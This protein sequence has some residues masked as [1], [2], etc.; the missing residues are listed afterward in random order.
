MKIK[1][2]QCPNMPWR[3]RP[4]HEHRPVWR[5]D[6]NPVIA[7]N[8]APG[9]ARI[10]NSAVVPWKDHFIG[11]FR[12][13]DFTGVPH[14]RLGRS[15]DGLEWTFE[16]APIRF[17]NAEDEDGMSRYAY[18]PRLV[19]VDGVHY[20]IWC[21]DF[22]GPSIGLAKT[23][24]F[25]TFVRL[26]NAF[27]PFNR[28]GVLFPERIGGVYKMLSR[29]SDNGHTAFGDI[30]I[31]ESPDL[32]HWGRHRRVMGKND[33]WWQNLKIGGGPA[34]IKTDEG[35]LTF[36]HGVTRTCNGYV[37]SMGVALLDLETPSRVRL[38]SNRFCLTPE[39]A[40]EE[41][42]F[43]PNVVFPCAALADEDSG[44]IAIYYGA[45]DSVVALAYTDIDT[46]SAFLRTHHEDMP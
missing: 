2:V 16:D 23:D 43:V 19:A 46:I 1:G 13:E 33:S 26:E 27:L 15:P 11:V 5:H 42:G 6:A 22:H 28:N 32:I 34:P 31:S 8:P 40:Y 44:R 39:T 38:R 12:V 14:L 25:K 4:E 29:P 18:D 3:P 20:I 45:A 21:T 7:R 37:Y 24:D 41:T 17:V 30:F 10:F 9:V 35:W 36:Y